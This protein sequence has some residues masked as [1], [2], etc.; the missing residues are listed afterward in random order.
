MGIVHTPPFVSS[1][2]EGETIYESIPHLSV[3]G[4]TDFCI[5]TTNSSLLGGLGLTLKSLIVFLLLLGV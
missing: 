3:R 1:V 2:K 5:E 4:R